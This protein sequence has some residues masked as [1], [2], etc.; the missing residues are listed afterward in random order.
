MV[1]QTVHPGIVRILSCI[2]F[3]DAQLLVKISEAKP[4]NI[5]NLF[6]LAVKAA[7]EAIPVVYA[8]SAL[9]QDDTTFNHAHLRSLGLI[10]MVSG[11]WVLTVLGVG[12]IQAVTD[13]SLEAG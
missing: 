5:T 2:S 9:R 12:F 13:P 7:L 4:S 11:K 6:S 1:T 8:V 10:K 3:E